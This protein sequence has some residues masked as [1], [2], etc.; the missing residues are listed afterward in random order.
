MLRNMIGPVF[1]FRNCVFLLFFV[2][3]FQTSSSF[4]RENE[5]FKNKKI[6]PDPPADRILDQ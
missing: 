6:A 4:C 2:L 5:I 3:V 1:N